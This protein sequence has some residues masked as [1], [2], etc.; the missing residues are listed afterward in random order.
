MGIRQ[1]VSTTFE[2]IFRCHIKDAEKVSG[3]Q[4]TTTI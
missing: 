3:Y 4:D 1:G 2:S